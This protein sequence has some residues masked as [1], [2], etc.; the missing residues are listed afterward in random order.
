MPNGNDVLI[1]I[2]ILDASEMYAMLIYVRNV[3]NVKLIYDFLRR[4]PS[5]KE[6]QF[7]EKKNLIQKL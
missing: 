3:I 6:N 7:F 4:K 1:N 5:Y 2:K